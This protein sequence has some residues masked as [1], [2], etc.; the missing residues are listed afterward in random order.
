MVKNYRN[1]S[2]AINQ[3]CTLAE[4]SLSVIPINLD[5]PTK[6]FSQARAMS[7]NETLSAM[8]IGFDSVSKKYDLLILGEMG[9]SN[10]SS[11]TAIACSL[12]KGSPEKWTGYGTGISE[13][14]LKNKISV[15]KNALKLHGTRFDC[16]LKILSSFGGREIAAIVGSV[17]AARI[18]GIPV[19]LDGYISTVSAATL[20][21]FKKDI[22]DHCLISHL[23]PEPAHKHVVK[24][25]KK[26]PILDL[27]MRLG[28]A[29]GG[30]VAALILKAAL[31][32]H[33]KMLTFSEAGV[34]KK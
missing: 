17:I 33:N 28:E 10:T 11:A 19:L 14:K 32:T 20:T 34:T 12:F 23:S 30:A 22:L 25:L 29:S 21:L 4:I 26:N 16:V 1:G 13:L 18:K 24:Y 31:E 7:Y 27:D 6:D 2:G 3:L 8:Q 5:N 9:I 15:I